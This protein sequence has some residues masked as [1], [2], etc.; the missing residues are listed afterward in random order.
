MVAPKV[1]ISV[2]SSGTEAQRRATDTIFAVLAASGLSPR[3]M[4]KNEWSAEQPLRAIR[5]IIA[6]CHGAVI[7]AFTRYQFPEGFESTKNES[8]VALK[9]VKLPTVWNQIE[10]AL[11]YGKGLPLLVICEQGLRDDGLLEGKYDWRVFWTNFDT[12]DLSSNK[13]SGFVQSWKK[14]VDEHVNSSSASPV[15]GESDLS[16]ITMAK[17]LGLLTVPQVVATL[18]AIVSALVA[19]A[20]LGF[21]VGASKWPWQ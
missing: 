21:K 15:L 16:K 9:D 14:L 13:F 17:I 1:F 19:V 8:R 3:Q 5:K 6:E 2:G 11:A 12:L 18:S 7:I 4:E 10:A 20:T